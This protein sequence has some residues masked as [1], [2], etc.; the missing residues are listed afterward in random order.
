MASSSRSLQ[1]Q[2]P[3]PIDPREDDPLLGP[4]D[5]AYEDDVPKDQE[6]VFY[7]LFTG[8][9]ILC[10]RSTKKIKIKKT[11]LTS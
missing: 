1:E 11:V 6:S 9:H 3:E 2:L 5:E 4:R 7:N 8:G 10:N